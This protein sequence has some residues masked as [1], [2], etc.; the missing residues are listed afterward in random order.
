M[1]VALVSCGVKTFLALCAFA[2]LVV[3]GAKLMTMFDDMEEP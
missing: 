3:A 1:T 2:A